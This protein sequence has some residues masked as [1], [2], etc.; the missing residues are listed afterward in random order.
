M[1]LTVCEMRVWTNI[2]Q[3]HMR[4]ELSLAFADEQAQER[5]QF[6]MI[7]HNNIIALI[8]SDSYV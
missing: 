8:Y 5:I 1:T 6:V 4:R 2:Q 7:K 3:C